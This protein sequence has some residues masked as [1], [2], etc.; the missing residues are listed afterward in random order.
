MIE[1]LGPQNHPASYPNLPLI[2]RLRIVSLILRNCMPLYLLL[3]INPCQDASR[4][5]NL[6]SFCRR[7]ENSLIDFSP[8]I[9]KVYSLVVSCSRQCHPTNSFQRPSTFIQPH[10]RIMSKLNKL[11]TVQALFAAP[12]CNCSNASVFFLSRMSA[13]TAPSVLA[14][15]FLPTYSR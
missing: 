8:S 9:A 11:S 6:F 12:A 5:E 13:C 3:I 1:R 2:H 7:F 10:H 14:D 15:G 4:L